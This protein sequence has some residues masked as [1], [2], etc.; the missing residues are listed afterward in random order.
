MDLFEANDGTSLVIVPTIG[1]ADEGIVEVVE[2]GAK[3]EHEEMLEIDGLCA[4]WFPGIVGI[5]EDVVFDVGWYLDMAETTGVVDTGV[6]DG[7]VALEAWLRGVDGK[8]VE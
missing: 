2:L 5:V 6:V 4:G 8:F 3:L 7:G 1:L